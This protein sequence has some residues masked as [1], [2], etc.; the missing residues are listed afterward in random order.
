MSRLFIVILLFTT[1]SLTVTPCQT[2]ARNSTP[3]QDFD[4]DDCYDNCPCNISGFEQACAEC[5]QKCDRE[6]WRNFDE[7]IKKLEKEN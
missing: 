2:V 3:F 1:L 5:V 6:F 7:K 4:R